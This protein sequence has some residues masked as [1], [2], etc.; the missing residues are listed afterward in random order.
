MINRLKA[1]RARTPLHKVWFIA[2]S[3]EEFGVENPESQLN[4]PLTL[5]IS[6]N[7]SS[8]VFKGRP[9]PIAVSTYG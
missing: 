3:L 1:R 8:Q 4:S 7:I 6:F 5:V 9:I 2:A